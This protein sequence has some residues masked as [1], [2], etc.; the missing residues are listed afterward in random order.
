MLKICAKLNSAI[1]NVGLRSDLRNTARESTVQVGHFFARSNVVTSVE[2]LKTNR[3]IQILENLLNA[4]ISKDVVSEQKLAE[5]ERQLLSV[6]GKL[7]SASLNEAKKRF[8]VI[9]A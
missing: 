7:K 6:L 1:V 5:Y 3:K 2:L 4:E 8:Q 9:T